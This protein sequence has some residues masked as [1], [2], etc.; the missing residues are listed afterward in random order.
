M[1][2]LRLYLVVGILLLAT[3]TWLGAQSHQTG[4]FPHYIGKVR[5]SLQQKRL[6][7]NLRIQIPKSTQGKELLLALPMNRFAQKDGRGLR[8][9]RETPI[10][11][12]TSFSENDD[13]LL[14][15]GFSAGS[16]EI[17]SV[18][19]RTQPIK[20]QLETNPAL[21]IGYSVEHGLLRVQVDEEIQEIE[22]EFQTNF[23]ER[24]QEG[25]VDGILMSALWYPQLLI[26]TESGWDTRLDLPSPGT[27]EI[28]WSSE[29]SGQLIS[30]PL[31]TAV[32]SNEPVLLPKTNLPI[33]SFPL[34]FGNKFQKHEDA[35]LVESFYQ[36]NYE[37]RVGLIHGWT[38]E[39]M[40]FIE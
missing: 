28:E 30:T 25:I 24:Y 23:P 14:P 4:D 22:I 35:P 1:N 36:N 31:A 38:E 6:E 27:F 37:R 15:S 26:P 8:R 9:P 3:S 11:A 34:I 10:F 21:E 33:T 32:S 2:Q 16:I 29:E 13:P 19:N 20:Y 18:R 40:A 12:K 5:F 17:K 39:F 7:G